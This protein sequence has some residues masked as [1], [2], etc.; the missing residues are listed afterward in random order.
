MGVKVIVQ[1]I[2]G[3]DL[4]GYVYSDELSERELTQL[5][6]DPKMP[7]GTELLTVEGSR[8]TLECWAYYCSYGI[9]LNVDQNYLIDAIRDWVTFNPWTD[10]QDADERLV[11]KYYDGKE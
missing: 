7:L 8:D 3:N 11:D 6:L 2:K 1:R 9:K 10:Q 4:E 5:G